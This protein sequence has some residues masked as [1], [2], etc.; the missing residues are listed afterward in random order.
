[1]AAVGASCVF[2]R[3]DFFSPRAGPWPGARAAGAALMAAGTPGTALRGGAGCGA[4]C[5]AKCGAACG[6]CWRWGGNVPLHRGQRILRVGGL[7]VGTRRGVAQC[8]HLPGVDAKTNS[9]GGGVSA[10]NTPRH[11]LHRTRLPTGT[12]PLRNRSATRQNGHASAAGVVTKVRAVRQTGHGKVVAIRYSRSRRAAFNPCGS[13]QTPGSAD[14]P[15]GNRR[16]PCDVRQPFGPS[17]RSRRATAAPP[18]HSDWLWSWQ[19]AS[20][21]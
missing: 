6:G 17:R 11:L 16:A 3:D 13:L 10:V 7:V 9:A 4:A 21:A 12:E 15:A 1:M 20:A 8:G 18:D 2:E 19:A 14:R 5:G